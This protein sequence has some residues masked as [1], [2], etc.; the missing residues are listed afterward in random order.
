[1]LLSLL[2]LAS[3]SPDV[4]DAPWSPALAN[5]KLES[6]AFA[7]GWEPPK[8]ERDRN[9][10]RAKASAAGNWFF[11]CVIA[12]ERPC[13]IGL[14]VGLGVSGLMSGLSTPLLQ[15]HGNKIY[16]GISKRDL[17][18]WEYPKSSEIVRALVRGVSG[19]RNDSALSYVGKGVF[20]F[21]MSLSLLRR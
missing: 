17:S 11:K 15:D 21:L 5:E 19:T 14:G 10:I 7:V 20:L 16:L 9:I 3:P 12:F 8:I 4:R 1:M 18:F 13:Y 6:A 2:R